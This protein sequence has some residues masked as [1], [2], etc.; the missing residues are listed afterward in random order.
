MDTF[1]TI[2]CQEYNDNDSERLVLMV[3]MVL[4]VV[5]GKMTTISSHYGIYGSWIM[6]A[7]NHAHPALLSSR[8]S[9]YGKIGKSKFVRLRDKHTQFRR[10]I[11]N[12]YACAV[13]CNNMQQWPC[14]H[15]AKSNPNIPPSHFRVRSEFLGCKRVK[16]RCTLIH[17][18][19]RSR[20]N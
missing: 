16:F 2:K 15:P 7:C 19:Q 17:F 18:S 11:Q 1:A 13:Y 9:R 5:V 4:M 8:R 6:A 3:L 20:T 14:L 12:C 10:A